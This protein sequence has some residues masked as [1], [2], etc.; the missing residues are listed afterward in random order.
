MVI[1]SLVGGYV[2]QYY[3]P[4]WCFLIYSSVSLCVSVASLGLSREIDT[5][6]VDQLNGFCVDL[7]RSFTETLKIRHIPEIYMTLFFLLAS[8]TFNPGFGEFGFYY[9]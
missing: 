7:K 9:N 3:E 2:N 8:S 1:G 5:K 6:G 4:K